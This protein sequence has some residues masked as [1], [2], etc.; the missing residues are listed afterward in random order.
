LK[1][2]LYRKLRQEGKVDRRLSKGCMGKSKCKEGGKEERIKKVVEERRRTSQR[3][4]GHTLKERE[5]IARKVKK[6]GGESRRHR[7]ERL[8]LGASRIGCKGRDNKNIM[9]QGVRGIRRSQG[10]EK[11]AGRPFGLKKNYTNH[12]RRR[13][14]I[15]ENRDVPLTTILKSHEPKPKSTTNSGKEGT[16]RGRLEKIAG[17]RDT[18]TYS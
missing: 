5:K 16:G 2:D 6:E 18:I 14:I 12:V 15:N 13:N 17:R 11:K 3:E 7:R 10:S 9:H 8:L 4:G 1:P